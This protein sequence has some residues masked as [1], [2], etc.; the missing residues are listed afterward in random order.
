M[1]MLRNTWALLVRMF[2]PKWNNS[3]TGQNHRE[4]R[5]MI[6]FRSQHWHEIDRMLRHLGS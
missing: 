4:N 6:R 5:N 1:Q 3:R 2:H